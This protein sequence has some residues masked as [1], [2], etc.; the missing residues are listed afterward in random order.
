[1]KFKAFFFALQISALAF[2]MAPRAATAG[3]APAWMHAVVNAPIPAHDEKTDAVNLYSEDIT[4]VMSDSKIKMIERRAYKILRPGGRTYGIAKTYIH[5]N[6]KMNAIRAWCIPAQGKDY[7]VKDKEAVEGSVGGVEYS[8]LITDTKEKYL[9]IPAADPG[10]IVGYEIEM[11]ERPYILQ[12]WWEF[13]ETAPVRE[14]HYVLQLP[15]GWEFRS[16]WM[17]HAEVMPTNIGGN[18]WQWVV[19]DVPGIRTED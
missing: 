17:N 18:Q 5:S 1:M 19:S 6:Q 8:A 10:N 2:L 15:T 7:E 4:I 13:Q 11:E 3:D 9:Q 16:T 14:A 12:D